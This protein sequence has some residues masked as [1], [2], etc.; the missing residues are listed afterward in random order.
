MAQKPHEFH[1]AMT[2]AFEAADTGTVRT[3]AGNG[4][5]GM[6]ASGMPISPAREASVKKAAKQ[7]A[8][9]RAAR[10]SLRHAT[11]PTLGQTQTTAH[12]GLGLNQPK[13][14]PVLTKK[15]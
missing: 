14:G 11:A 13:L 6:S 8:V 12:G 7:S 4:R 15:F 2:Q 1:A 10:A 9:N 5:Y 3:N